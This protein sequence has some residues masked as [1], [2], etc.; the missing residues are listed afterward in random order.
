MTMLQDQEALQM[1]LNNLSAT[2]TNVVVN[3]AGSGVR[4]AKH[5]LH[6]SYTG[7][8][9]NVTEK[10][11][12]YKDVSLAKFDIKKPSPVSVP[13]VT[14]HVYVPSSEHVAEIVG[15][16]GKCHC[17]SLPSVNTYN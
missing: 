11:G 1:V 10:N 9:Y 12:A 5:M 4:P 8:F 13:N 17:S 3:S 2:M 6:P 14:E 7:M 15:R 16:Q